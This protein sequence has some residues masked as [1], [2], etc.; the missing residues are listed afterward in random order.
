MANTWHP[1]RH[2]GNEQ[3]RLLAEEKIKEIN[4]A[5]KAL[6]DYYQVHQR[7]PLGNEG[8]PNQSSRQ[9]TAKGP[10]ENSP[11]KT[12]SP[13]QNQEQ[14]FH[15][16]SYRETAEETPK[17]SRLRKIVI[18]LIVAGSA[19]GVWSK[20]NTSMP[21]AGN[22]IQ[23]IKENS[24]AP[25]PAQQTLT[26]SN[27][28]KTATSSPIR[29]FTYGSKVGEVYA[30]Q[31]KP[32]KV[33]GDIWYYGNSQVFF[34]NGTVMS[35][36]AHAEN[37]LNVVSD[38]KLGNKPGKGFFTIGSTQ[39]EV[40][41]AQGKPDYVAENSWEYGMSKVY[42]SNGLVVD[43]YSSPLDPLKAKK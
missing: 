2:N 18:I 5:Y 21:E 16:S 34:S 31:G 32:T 30:A 10:G 4:L 40:R 23:A 3:A 11:K 33:E 38:P 7:L 14:D 25:S 22:T 12:Y 28:P 27:E 24:G 1:D 6:S 19:Y 35:W 20:F 41:R 29:Y 36:I 9:D 15:S 39:D 13:R 17:S 43:W 26:N 8:G 42:F 37:P